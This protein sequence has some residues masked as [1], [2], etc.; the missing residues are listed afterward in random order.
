MTVLINLVNIIIFFK[1]ATDCRSFLNIIAIFTV[2]ISRGKNNAFL[3]TQLIYCTLTARCP[4]C[5]YTTE[6]RD[7]DLTSPKQSV[8]L[9]TTRQ[10]VAAENFNNRCRQTL[11][12]PVDASFTAWRRG[13]SYYVISPVVAEKRENPCTSACST[14]QGYKDSCLFTRQRCITT[15]QAGAYISCLS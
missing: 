10:S 8:I 15:D 13:H 9:H 1:N 4:V 2:T 6:M 7:T 5:D 14:A 3:F 12:G 11:T